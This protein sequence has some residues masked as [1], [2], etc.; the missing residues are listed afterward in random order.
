MSRILI[1]I[2][3]GTLDGVGDVPFPAF[4]NTVS[5]GL[6]EAAE[7]ETLVAPALGRRVAEVNRLKC[8][9]TES[10]IPLH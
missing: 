10:V 6:S 4:L 1:S 9:V 8:R 7:R 3:Y 2:S 5:T